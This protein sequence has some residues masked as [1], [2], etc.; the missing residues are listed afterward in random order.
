[1][2]PFQLH[3]YPLSVLFEEAILIGVET[4]TLLYPSGGNSPGADWLTPLCVLERNSQVIRK[5]IATT[6]NESDL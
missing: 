4:D 5:L 6:L 2:L 3:I 1:M